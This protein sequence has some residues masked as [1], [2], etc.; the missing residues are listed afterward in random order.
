M[1]RIDKI[2][3]PVDFSEP[4]KQALAYGASLA[5]QFKAKLFIAHVVPCTPFVAEAYPIDTFECE[6]TRYEAAKADMA[7]LLPPEYTDKIQTEIIVKVGDVHDELLGIMSSEGIDLVVMG[8]HGRRAFER[9][10]LGSVTERMLRKSA[11]PVLTVS[12]LDASHEI[13][14]P[15]PVQLRRIVYATDL[16]S[17]SGG[18]FHFAAELARAYKIPLSVVHVFDALENAY[19]GAEM[20]VFVPED[21]VQMRKNVKER[22][23]RAV[24]RE[25]Q[26]GITIDTIMRNGKPYQEIINYAEEAK[27]DLIVVDM[28]YKGRLERAVLG[29]TAERLIRAATVPVLSVPVPMAVQTIRVP[30]ETSFA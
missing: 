4:S 12:H 15:D 13:R 14:T 10:L 3:V 25:L 27:A 7:T 1:I 2:L 16:S 28:R 20:G 18:G 19:W 5:L 21:V 30:E 9:F 17:E 29:A 23:D 26:G 8:T 22:I 11:V 24:E 6:K